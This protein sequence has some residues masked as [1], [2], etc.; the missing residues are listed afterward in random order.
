MLDAGAYG[1]FAGGADDEWTLRDNVEAFGRW[2]LR[3][4]VLVDVAEPVDRDDRARHTSVALP[5][6]VAPD[7]V[8]ARSRI[9]TARSAWRGRP[10]PRARSC[11]SRRF[12][13]LDPADVVATGATRWYQL[14]VPRDEGLAARGDRAGDARTGSRALVLTVDTP[15]LG[16]RERDLRTRLPRSRSSC[17]H[18]VRSATA[19]SRR[20]SVVRADLGVGD[21][22]R[23][24]AASPRSPSCRSS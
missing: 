18:R 8:P 2:Q 5:V 22:A 14:Y 11:A 4:R 7:R 21:V 23:H 20:T 3:P 9:R 24:R 19:T 12:A 1:Y 16:R 13:D 10:R 17:A 15:V 6:L